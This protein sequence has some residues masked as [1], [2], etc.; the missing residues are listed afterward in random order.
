MSS[1]LK[2]CVTTIII[3]GIT[4]LVF[5][6]STSIML[7]IRSVIIFTIL[8]IV[9][10]S[11]LIPTPGES[12]ISVSFAVNLAAILVLGVPEA[13]WIACIGVMVRSVKH[14]GNYVHILNTPWYKTLFNGANILLSAGIAGYFY[15]FFG[16]VPEVIDFNNLFLPLM[17]SIISYVLINETIMSWLM[18]AATGEAFISS[19]LSNL[20]FAARDCIFVAP[21]GVLMAI[22]YMKYNI[23]GIFLFLGPLLLA[24]YSYK[25]YI[26]MRR[27]Y[28]D[29]VKSLSQAIE[30]KDP[31]TQGHS[32]RVG[33]YAVALGK[34]LKLSNKKL[35]NLKMA[36]ILHDIGKIGI[37]ESIL[38]KP[39]KLTEE[40][41]DKIKTHPENGYK[42]IQDIE[43]LKD[44]SE[45]V[46]N[47]HE[48]MDG[49]GYP[50]GKRQD[51]IRKEA[52]ILSIA[53]V[54]DALTSDRPY[55]KA[56]TVEQAFAII[57][58]G[59]GKHFDAQLA[60]EFMD[61]IKEQGS[62]E[63]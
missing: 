40:E 4:Y 19:W 62:A 35:E 8:S 47:H 15:I 39:G 7:D 18:S 9:A 32:M 1:K 17:T 45:I 3:L 21:L 44:V 25:L 16:G 50:N 26:D 63:H 36:A 5:S 11:L 60:E 30:V 54:Y 31:Y 27:I 58:E 53:D 33:E 49:T 48:K 22:A 2:L 14:Q 20:F 28:I 38:N 59:K 57:E 12:A 10:E 23:L 37:E 34:R 41:F 52:A 61:M 24:R 42:I 6:V 56:L 29:T 46:L 13:A 51:E 55:R 43:F